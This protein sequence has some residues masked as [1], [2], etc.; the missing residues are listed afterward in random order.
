MI[1]SCI[2]THNRF[3][4]TRRCVES[5]LAT[6]G[7]DFRLVIVDNA[8][9]DKTRDWLYAWAACQPHVYVSLMEA[10]Y[11]PGKAT[12]RG[13]DRLLGYEPDAQLLHRSDNDIEYLPGWREEVEAQFRAWPELALLGLLNLHEDGQPEGEG[14]LPVGRV[15]G[16]VVMPA[17][18]YRGGLRWPEGPWDIGAGEDGHMSIAAG[19]VGL[20]ARLRRTVANNMA[21]G[22]YWD[23]PEYYNATAAVRGIADPEHS[24]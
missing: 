24:V 14:I 4:Y 2:V 10:N 16:N 8:S 20:V 22:R 9:S 23:F 15:G 7:P 1:L 6:V 12:N 3:A 19:A 11:Y 5:Y 21:F 18:L 17:R 13:W